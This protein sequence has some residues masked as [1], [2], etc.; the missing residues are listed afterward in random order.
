ML[1]I[2]ELDVFT[3]SFPVFATS[4]YLGLLE[5]CVTYARYGPI[6]PYRAL[7]SIFSCWVSGL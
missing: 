1:P 7:E 2:D 4:S 6:L 5:F 3:P